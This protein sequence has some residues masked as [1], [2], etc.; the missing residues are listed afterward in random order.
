MSGL[1]L[2][3]TDVACETM[4]VVTVTSE[5]ERAQLGSQS[6]LQLEGQGRPSTLKS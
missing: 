4:K 3:A 6:T 2:S 5:Y 1:Q